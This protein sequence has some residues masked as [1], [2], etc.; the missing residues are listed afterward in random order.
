MNMLNNLLANLREGEVQRVCVGL[1]W[2]AVV[3]D[4]DGE[5]CCGLAS[6]LSAEHDHHSNPDI[7]LAGKLESLPCLDMAKL[8]CSEQPSEVSV[9]MAAVNALLP[10]HPHTW[11]EQ[12]AEDLIA[13]YGE[14]KRVVLFG[15][16][17][18]IPR[19][20]SRVGKLV[21]L[22]LSPRSG[23][24]P[25]SA[26]EDIVPSADIVAITGM[27]LLNHTFEGILELC[28]S[29]AVVIVLGPSTPLSPVLFE[30]GVEW[31]SGAIVENIDA[32]IR[33]EGQGGNFRQIRQSGVRLVNISRSSASIA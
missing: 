13:N 19:L 3:I 8:I 14:G 32:V 31:I 24:L 1:H 12:N 16:F 28:N 4:I 25:S 6:T 33:T 22:E 15:H 18:F 17:P 20:H 5:Q 26:A 30:H 21:V 23:D 2:T 7:S 11:V 27:A 9:G 29:K 10:R